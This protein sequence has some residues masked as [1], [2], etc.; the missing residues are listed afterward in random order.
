[1]NFSIRSAA[2]GAED[3]IEK[4]NQFLDLAAF[5]RWPPK[6]RADI[7]RAHAAGLGVRLATSADLPALIELH[8]VGAAVAG[9]PVKPTPYLE[10]VFELSQRAP[11]IAR[12]TVAGRGPGRPPIGCLLTL[13]GP[14]TMS[15]VLPAAL[16]AERSNQPIPLLIDEAVTFA[17]GRGS[18][19]FNM[20]SSPRLSDPVFKFKE[21]W[22]ALTGRYAV[23]VAYP[24]G[25]AAAEAV[26]EDELRA[27]YPYYFIRPF[28]AV[29]GAFAE[30]PS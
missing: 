21:R 9:A 4:F 13:Q 30:P 6:R 28:G 3:R 11:D 16:M 24:R 18:R 22:G 14:L 10:A 25:R 26:P 29:G 12:W 23:L 17:R 7:A 2:L 19:Y 8:R 20:E 27:A 15:Y 1:L 5:E